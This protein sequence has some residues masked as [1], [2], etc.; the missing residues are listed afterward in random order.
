MPTKTST[1]STPHVGVSEVLQSMVPASARINLTNGPPKMI[2]SMFPTKPSTKLYP[3]RS[4]P[5][6]LQRI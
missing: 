4:L 6:Y 3:R 1:C 2:C 5:A